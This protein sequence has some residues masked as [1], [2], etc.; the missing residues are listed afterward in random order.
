MSGAPIDV[1]KRIPLF[2]ELDDNELERVASVFK[3]RHFSEGET[4][5]QQGWVRPPS[6]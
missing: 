1:L 3:E 2:A 4:I 5:I 6:S